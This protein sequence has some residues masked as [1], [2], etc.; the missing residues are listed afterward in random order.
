MAGRKRLTKQLLDTTQGRSMLFALLAS[1]ALLRCD[2]L[3]AKNAT[4]PNVRMERLRSSR[5][6]E[7]PASQRAPKLSVLLAAP[8][9]NVSFPPAPVMGNVVSGEL[10][11]GTGV[12]AG[13]PHAKLATAP[14]RTL[15]SARRPPTQR[16][17][18][19]R[20]ISGLLR[21]GTKFF[22]ARPTR[23]AMRPRRAYG[24]PRPA[25]PSSRSS[26]VGR[27]WPTSEIF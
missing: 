27:R 6:L 7:G 22:P 9:R 15:R 24:Q 25:R 2:P 20:T 23:R 4:E 14:R 11:R 1:A 26:L 21:S 10:R 19:P 18:S 5:P 13:H 3:P 17:P 12:Q 16:I 8:A